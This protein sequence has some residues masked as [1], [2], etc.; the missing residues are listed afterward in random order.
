MAKQIISDLQNL[1]AKIHIIASQV[2]GPLPTS[3]S[4]T[5]NGGRVYAFYQISGYAS[6]AGTIAQWNAQLDGVTQQV[7]TLA[8]SAASSHQTS[9]P[10]IRDL[11]VLSAVSHTLG[12]TAGTGL[13]TDANARTT[14]F[15][16]ELP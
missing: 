7:A 16:L 4:F 6:A 8:L 3:G 15:A 13:V 14:I 12:V 9:T 10:V 5:P 2:A 1:G 11:G